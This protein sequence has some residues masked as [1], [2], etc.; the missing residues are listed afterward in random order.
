MQLHLIGLS[1]FVCFWV[2]PCWSVGILWSSWDWRSSFQGG[3]TPLFGTPRTRQH[4]Q[5]TREQSLEILHYGRKLNPA[6]R[7]DRQ[8]AVPLSYVTD[9]N[10][11]NRG[12][13]MQ[14]WQVFTS[15]SVVAVER[16][17]EIY[18][19][20][21]SD[22]YLHTNSPH[23]I[24]P[25]INMEQ[26]IVFITWP[27]VSMPLWFLFI[28]SISNEYF[29]AGP[30]SVTPWAARF[31]SSVA[32]WRWF[33]FQPAC[34][35][36]YI[37]SLMLFGQNIWVCSHKTNTQLAMFNN[38]TAGHT[39][40]RTGRQGHH[41]IRALH[42]NQIWTSTIRRSGQLQTKK[43]TLIFPGGSSY[44]SNISR[45]YLLLGF[46]ARIWKNSLWSC[47]GPKTYY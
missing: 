26:Q 33:S 12:I 14:R 44:V 5:S 3:A 1:A 35:R 17:P 30:M 20:E 16:I 18:T 21:I 40:V 31:F 28:F 22:S 9:V 41:S 39:T 38:I 45:S 32:N 43:L 29:N 24:S 42:P 25:A 7:E 23:N 34:N 13:Q 11:V 19:N 6:Y 46:L 8:W 47:D 37:W 4:K 10:R 36:R 27:Y 2:R 15:L